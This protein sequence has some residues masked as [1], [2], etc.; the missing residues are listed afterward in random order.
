MEDGDDDDYDNVNGTHISKMRLL[1][2]MDD[3]KVFAVRCRPQHEKEAVMTLM[4]KFCAL[5]NKPN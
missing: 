1:P 4:N 2:T 5:R 3:P